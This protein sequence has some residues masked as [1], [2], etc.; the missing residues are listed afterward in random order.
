MIVLKEEL[1]KSISAGVVDD[2]I[3]PTQKEIEKELEKIKEITTGENP[4]G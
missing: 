3:P 1:T 2:C 4:G